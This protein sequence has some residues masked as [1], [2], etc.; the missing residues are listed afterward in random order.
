MLGYRRVAGR[1]DS[2]ACKL[3]VASWVQLG[4]RKR[5]ERIRIE[6]IERSRGKRVERSSRNDQSLV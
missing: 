2:G 5:I 6:R 3:F 4:E 1:F